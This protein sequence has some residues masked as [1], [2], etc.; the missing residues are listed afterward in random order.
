[1]VLG[2]YDK[3]AVPVIAV[4][5][6]GSQTVSAPVYQ[7]RPVHASCATKGP[8]AYVVPLEKRAEL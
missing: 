4:L 3:P 8:A 7:T 5:V 6:F 2:L 1:M